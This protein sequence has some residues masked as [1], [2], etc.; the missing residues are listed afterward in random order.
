MLHSRRMC[1][2]FQH[3]TS[4]HKPLFLAKSD[5]VHDDCDI[6]EEDIPTP[7]TFEGT[8]DQM[9]DAANWENEIAHENDTSA[10][11]KVPSTITGNNTELD[12]RDNDDQAAGSRRSSRI[13]HPPI[14][15]KDYVTPVSKSHPS[16]QSNY[17]SYNNM[18]FQ[19]KAY[20]SKFSTEI[21]PKNY[22]KAVK[23]KR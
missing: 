14:F 7:I 2:L 13:P 22:K 8:T 17:I 23:D 6:Y 9:G 10:E 5:I 1:S 20:L 12:I 15:M 19:Y 3:T 4:I 11:M 16:S 18:T 21:E